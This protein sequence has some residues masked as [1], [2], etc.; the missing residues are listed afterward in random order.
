[1]SRPYTDRIV[2]SIGWLEGRLVEGMYAH[3]AQALKDFGALCRKRRRG[4]WQRR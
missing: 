4:L 2:C 3:G 1:M